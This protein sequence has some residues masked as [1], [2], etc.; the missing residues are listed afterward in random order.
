VASTCARLAGRAKNHFDGIS[1]VIVHTIFYI[2]VSFFFAII[3]YLLIERP[4][5][6]F[7]ERFTFVKA[8]EK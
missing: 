8:V 2:S 7:K 3:S 4:F 6:L 1:A 5:L